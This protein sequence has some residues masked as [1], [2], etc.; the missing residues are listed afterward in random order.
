MISHPRSASAGI[1]PQMGPGVPP[2]GLFPIPGVP[3]LGL[4]GGPIIFPLKGGN[5]GVISLFLILM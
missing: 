2:L 5:Y 4:R 3:P 1:I